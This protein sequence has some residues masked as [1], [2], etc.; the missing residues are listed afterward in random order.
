MR[1]EMRETPASSSLGRVGPEQIAKLLAGDRARIGGKAI[2]QR[3][4]LA[5]RNREG[6]TSP[7]DFRWAEQGHPQICGHEVGRS[8]CRERT[9]HGVNSSA[10]RHAG[11][12]EP[13]EGGGLP[14]SLPS[15]FIRLTERLSAITRASSAPDAHYQ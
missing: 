13:G 5:P 10:R 4:R 2:E 1:Q 8:S 6:A 9:G 11:W 14:S 15:A 7:C 3:A 12:N